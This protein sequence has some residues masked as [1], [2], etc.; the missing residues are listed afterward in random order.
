MAKVNNFEELAVWQKA[1]VLNKHIYT[2]TRRDEFKYDTRFVQQIRAAAGSIMDNIAEGF[3]RS[4]NKEF[5]NFL[6]IAKGSCG[7]LRSQVIRAYDVGYLNEEEYASLHSECKILG[8]SILNLI[9]SIKDSDYKG[10]KYT[11]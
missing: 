8:S 4:G 11:L 6:Y 10:P 7:E 1:R 2:Y 9:L 3:E 5:K